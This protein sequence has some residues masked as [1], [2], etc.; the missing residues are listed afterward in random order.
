ML[1]LK[2][3]KTASREVEEELMEMGPFRERLLTDSDYEDILPP[4]IFILLRSDSLYILKITRDG[5]G[6]YY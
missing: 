4:T 2:F 6:L 3:G 5:S 1:R